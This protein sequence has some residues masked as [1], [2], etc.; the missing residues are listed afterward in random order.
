MI[1]QILAR[2]EKTVED[3]S[4]TLKP[5]IRNNI[6]EIKVSINEM[7]KILNGKNSRM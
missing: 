4:E 3:M 5:E 6:A 1:I 2:L 7:R